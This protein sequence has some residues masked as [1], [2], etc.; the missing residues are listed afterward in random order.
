M[1]QEEACP[2]R[3]ILATFRTLKEKEVLDV[4]WVQYLRAFQEG[5]ILLNI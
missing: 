3:T 5:A 2:V 1:I 4:D